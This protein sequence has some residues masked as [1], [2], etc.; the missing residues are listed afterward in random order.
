MPCPAPWHRIWTYFSRELA[1]V[2]GMSHRKLLSL[3]KPKMV[4]VA[5]YQRRGAV[6]FHDIIRLDAAPPANDPQAVASP[7]EQFTV[8]VLEEAVRAVRD[9]AVVFCPELAVSKAQPQIEHRGNPTPRFAGET[10]SM[11]GPYEGVARANSHTRRWQGTPRST[12][13]KR[14]KPWVCTAAADR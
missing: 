4:K 9:S 2:M 5:E 1:S 14:R 11:S 12:A 7:S 13:K 8:E 10:P 3:V 6:H